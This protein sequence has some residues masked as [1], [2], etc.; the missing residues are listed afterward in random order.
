VKAKG[1]GMTPFL[2]LQFLL[3]TTGGIQKYK[4]QSAQDIMRIDFYS[5]T[6]DPDM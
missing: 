2:L 6:H 3:D 4:N 1:V 5:G